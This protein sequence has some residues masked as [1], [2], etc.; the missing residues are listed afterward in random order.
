MEK[1]LFDQ[2][3]GG[4]GWKNYYHLN[5]SEEEFKIAKE[6]GYMFDYPDYITHQEYLDRIKKIVEMIKVEDVSNS[7][8]Y[9]LSTRKLEYRSVLGSYWYAIAMPQHEYKDDR[10]CPVCNWLAWEKSPDNK[11]IINGLNIFNFS[12]YKWGGGIYDWSSYALFDLEQFIKMVKFDH[13]EEDEK[14]LHDILACVY[15]LKPHNK[16]GALR[17]MICKKRYLKPINKRYLPY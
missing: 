8:L 4:G 15:D 10:I 7:F 12:R 1:I 9:S 6:Q 3:W 17:D 13:T 11:D 16:A 14:I 5:I 2:Y